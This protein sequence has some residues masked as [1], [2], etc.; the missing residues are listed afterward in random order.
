MHAEHA[1]ALCG[2]VLRS[3]LALTTLAAADGADGPV[4]ELAMRTT[5]FERRDAWRPHHSIPFT[6]SERPFVTVYRTDE[7]AIEAH[8]IATFAVRLQ[9]QRIDCHLASD[10]IGGLLL[11]QLVVDQ[12]VPRM[13]H[14]MG[15]PCL[16]AS[17]VDFGWGAIAF[18]G[19]TGAGKS[20]LSAASC[21]RGALLVCDD[22]LGLTATAD[23]I[24]AHRGYGSVRLWPDA[25]QALRE[26]ADELPSA[27]PRVHKKRAPYSMVA[28][29]VPLAAVVRI[30]RGGGAAT[31]KRLRGAES[32]RALGAHVH[33]MVEDDEHGMRCEFELLGH[34]AERVPVHE[35]AVPLG[36]DELPGAIATL[37]Q[38]LTRTRR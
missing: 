11:E 5:P 16:H 8:G 27:T 9:A 34:I 32:I 6:D 31:L 20:T 1:Y 19:E 35:L 18:V 38:E 22:C 2:V 14:P 23:G 3:E 15:R 4:I 24:V 33:R 13:L 21:E 30:R 25:A 12:I 17:A 10:A 37:R 7:Y 36:H 26:D 29:D 28:G